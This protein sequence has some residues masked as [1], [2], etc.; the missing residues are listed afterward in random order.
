MPLYHGRGD[1]VLNFSI[2]QHSLKRF[3]GE[4]G[5]LTPIEFGELPFSP[6][7]VFIIDNVPAGG[8]RGDH[9][10]K[11]NHQFFLCIR[12]EFVIQAILG[13]ALMRT[14]KMERDS[15]EAFH[16]PPLTWIKLC[17]FSEDAI[18]AVFASHP[19]DPGDYINDY[20]EYQ[21]ICDSI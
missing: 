9:A 13:A 8:V 21:K 20:K 4:L 5:C 2:L 16:A 19:Y 15:N 1:S 7:R 14:F 17:V 3:R 10:H 12:G 11:V 18:C 6:K